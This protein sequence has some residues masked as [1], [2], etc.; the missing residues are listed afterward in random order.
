MI[1]TEPEQIEEV[2]EQTQQNTLMEEEPVGSL[3]QVGLAEG[4]LI[5]VVEQAT[6]IYEFD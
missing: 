4:E 3:K 1:M 2:K 6:D 5:P